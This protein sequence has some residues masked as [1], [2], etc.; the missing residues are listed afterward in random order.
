MRDKTAGQI[1]VGDH[2]VFWLDGRPE[3]VKMG[4]ITA[5]TEDTVTIG[6][7]T[8]PIQRNRIDRFRARR[9]ITV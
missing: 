1:K 7:N 6:A 8:E 3:W 4:V 9:P 5:L 2:G